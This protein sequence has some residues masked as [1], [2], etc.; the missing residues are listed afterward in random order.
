MYTCIAHALSQQLLELSALLL[1]G[2]HS[3]TQ[4]LVCCSRLAQHRLSLSISV[5]RR[6]ST[7]PYVSRPCLASD[8]G[9]GEPAGAECMQREDWDSA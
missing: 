9:T 5:D 2:V 8:S 1:S 7:P 4:S 6:D 3:A